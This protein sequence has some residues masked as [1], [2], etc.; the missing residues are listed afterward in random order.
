MTWHQLDTDKPDAVPGVLEVL[1]ARY[2]DKPATMSILDP[3]AAADS[4]VNLPVVDALVFW[5]DLMVHDPPGAA[6]LLKA[7]QNRF[8]G[9]SVTKAIILSVQPA[10]GAP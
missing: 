10:G 8:P 3:A 2:A 4:A 7:L 5:N 1:R 6:N 9:K